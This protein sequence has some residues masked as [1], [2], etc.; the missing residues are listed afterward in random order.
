[1]SKLCLAALGS[2]AE[3]MECG[4]GRQ[5]L[6]AQ[7]LE[8]LSPKCFIGALSCFAELPKCNVS[9]CHLAA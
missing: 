7:R 8:F 1:M 9:L 2:E 5:W 3:F 6:R 4:S